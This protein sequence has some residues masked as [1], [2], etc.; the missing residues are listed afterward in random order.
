MSN[1]IFVAVIKNGGE[2]V[3][4]RISDA[5]LRGK[6]MDLTI[7]NV[8][9]AI[10]SGVSISGLE[11]K[12]GKIV[13]N[14]GSIDRYP[15][16]EAST[17]KIT[18]QAIVIV[19]KYLNGYFKI[20]NAQGVTA[21]AEA[22]KIIQ[23]A[24]SCSIANGKVVK[25]DGS[26]FISAI[27][28]EYEILDS[29]T[30]GN[31]NLNC[32]R[33]IRTNIKRD[34]EDNNYVST[35]AI[36][37]I[38][39]YPTDFMKTVDH[40]TGLTIEQK[41]VKICQIIRTVN[42]MYFSLMSCL[43]LTPTFD[44]DTAAISLTRLMYNPQFINDLPESEA[45]FVFI[46]ECMHYIMRHVATRG[47]DRDHE[48]FNIAADLYINK[49]ITVEFNEKTYVKMP[50]SCLYNE[51]VNIDVDTP[52][53]IYAEMVQSMKQDNDDRLPGPLGNGKGNGGSSSD[54]IEGEGDN[55][56]NSTGR[57]DSRGNNVAKFRGQE[58]NISDNAK[59]IGGDIN[60]IPEDEKDITDEGSKIKAD[61]TMTRAESKNQREKTYTKEGKSD[62][63]DKL[64][65]TYKKVRINWKNLVKAKLTKL[66]Q[67]YN[68]YAHPDKRYLT[69]RIIVPGPFPGVPSE[70]ENVKVCI[71]TSGSISVEELAEF[72]GAMYQLFRQTKATG[73]L[74]L[75]HTEVYRTM[76][77]KEFKDVQQF[78]RGGVAAGGTDCECVFE[79]LTSGPYKRHLKPKP[80]LVI[81]LTDGCFKPVDKKYS[82]FDTVYVITGNN[83]DFEPSFGKAAWLE[84]A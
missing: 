77:F 4:F 69:R 40:R 44:I 53:S 26:S 79:Y 67:K 73:E 1:A 82:N 38:G 25:K 45:V 55:H 70:L 35:R 39:E 10:A 84:D 13:G 22:S 42:P 59:G 18:K 65:A 8:S 15:V 24:K 76:N 61:S 47:R 71:D 9:K 7:K 75:W 48:L 36:I 78:L 37:K 16:I 5:E 46:H 41:V 72:L 60:K 81:I 58:Y 6:V 3:G 30:D 11:L 52:E 2:T 83:R 34:I 23:L 74:L 29:S 80:S 51:A 49:F 64:L 31:V 68:T 17:G 19:G 21:T 27:N 14:N 50:K 43:E 54:N 12:N 63:L 66:G 57:H 56:E 32:V 62:R 20:C 33:D 28:G